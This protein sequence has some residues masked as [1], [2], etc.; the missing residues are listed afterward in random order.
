MIDIINRAIDAQRQEKI[1]VAM[2][3]L[4]AIEEAGMLP[5]VSMVL[6]DSDPENME[7]KGLECWEPEDENK[8]LRK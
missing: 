5:P 3:V 4:D 8:E 2:R 7:Y 6:D 1:E